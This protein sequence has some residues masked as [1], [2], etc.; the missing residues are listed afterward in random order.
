MNRPASIVRFEQFYLGHVVVGLAGSVRSLFYAD[1]PALDALRLQYGN[2]PL[3]VLMVL[4]L[5]TQALLW[6]GIA[7][8][9]WAAA[10]W[11]LAVLGAVNLAGA[12]Y[13]VFSFVA[14]PGTPYRDSIGSMLS[15]AAS[16]LLVVALVMM[17]RPDTRGWFGEEAAS[18]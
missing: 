18:A 3:I 17:F 11:V 10:K 7:R 12:L 13:L 6:F 14:V 2:A 8:G 5:A 15:L 1:N 4:A 16:A 9:G